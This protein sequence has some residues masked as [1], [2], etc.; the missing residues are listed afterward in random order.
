MQSSQGLMQGTG[1]VSPVEEKTT[2]LRYRRLAESWPKRLG[3]STPTC[4]NSRVSTWFQSSTSWHWLA[5]HISHSEVRGRMGGIRERRISVGGEK[6]YLAETEPCLR[7]RWG[8]RGLPFASL[9]V[10][11]SVEFVRVRVGDVPPH[12][13]VLLREVRAVLVRWWR[14]NAEVGIARMTVLS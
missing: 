10:L 9:A 3:F 2:R 6:E 7:N 1:K 13:E 12:G 8:L 14:R 11:V 4:I 5:A